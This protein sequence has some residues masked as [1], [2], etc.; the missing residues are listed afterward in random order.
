[1]IRVS[2]IT[3][4]CFLSTFSVVLLLVKCIIET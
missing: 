1:M 4:Q 3:G 2:M